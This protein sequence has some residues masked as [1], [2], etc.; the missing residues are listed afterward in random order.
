MPVG[1]KF[2]PGHDPRRGNGISRY[3]SEVRKALQAQEP[4]ERVCEVVAAL[5]A[6]AVGGDAK[7]AKVYLDVL[8]ASPSDADRIIK[9][10]AA[11]L[12]QL[13]REAERLEAIEQERKAL[14]EIE[15]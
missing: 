13:M 5:H 7:A 10:V 4:P 14:P 11:H 2:Q 9:G 1:K 15:K 8:G 6:A 12:D 3:E